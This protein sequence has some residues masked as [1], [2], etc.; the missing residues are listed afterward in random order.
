MFRQRH[1][2][3]GHLQPLEM[4]P[5]RGDI[6]SIHPLSWLH[7]GTINYW[8]LPR[9]RPVL[10]TLS[11]NPALVQK[12]DRREDPFAVSDLRLLHRVNAT[13]DEHSVPR[14]SRILSTLNRCKGLSQCPR[15][16][17]T[18]RR[19]Y[20]IVCS[21]PDA[22]KHRGQDPENLNF[23]ACTH[24]EHL[25]LLPSRG[26][27]TLRIHTHPVKVRERLDHLYPFLFSNASNFH[28]YVTTLVKVL[29]RITDW[30]DLFTDAW[31]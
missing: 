14:R 8:L 13:P 11:G 31:P 17:I 10:D 18:S 23:T 1:L 19:R 26:R 3:S 4:D 15:G 5:R 2:D 22:D 20:V 6:K 27:I 16:F 24:G 9:I 12:G 30:V 25:P 7:S 29:K 21:T 28:F